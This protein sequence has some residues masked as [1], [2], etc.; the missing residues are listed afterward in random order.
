MSKKDNYYEIGHLTNPLNIKVKNV[1]P[2]GRICKIIIPARVNTFLCHHNYFA[3]P[4]KTQIY[5]VDSINFSVGKFTEA[6][7]EIRND[8]KNIINASDKYSVIIEHIVKIMQKTLGIKNG[9]NVNAKNLHNISHGGLGSSS[10][11]AS[12]VAQAINILMGSILSVDDMTRL[13]SQNYV[14][15][16]TKKGFISSAASIGGS[17]A[18]GLSGKSLIIMGGRSE[19]WC[20]DNLP[21]DYYAILLYPKKIKNIS[22]AM[23][24]VL[25]KKE[26]SLLEIID[27]GWGD[28]KE[29]MLK[30]K[31]IP[32][33]NKKDYSALFRA[34]NMYTIGAFGDIPKYFKSRWIPFG[35]PF[36]SVIY[37]IFS[38]LFGTLKIDENCFFV[39]SNGPLIAVITNNSKEVLSLLSNFNKDFIIE[40][41]LLNNNQNNYQLIK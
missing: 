28:I 41:V 26:F 31:I 19:I 3:H 36:D 37:I 9:F 16:S 7:V 4:P 27:D 10:A 33:I 40:K 22:K 21:K 35:I 12:A 34:I 25:N 32:A 8:T 17:T 38:K 5:P 15:E 2:I 11:I 23:D 30:T 1:I 39:S 24:N 18:I 29:D 20:L 6:T 14:E 13:I